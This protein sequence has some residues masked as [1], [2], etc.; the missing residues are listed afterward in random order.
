MIQKATAMGTWWQAA[1]SRQHVC[2]CIMS[3]ADFFGET[4]NH[5]GDSTPLQPRFGAL[6]LLAFPQIKIT[7]ERGEVSDPWWNSG[8]YDREADDD[9]ENCVR[10]QDAYFEGDWGVAVLCTM[11]LYLV[12]SSTNVSIF[13]MT[14]LDTS[15]TNLAAPLHIYS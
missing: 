1:S 7:S 5:P 4:S 2:S 15:W 13:S 8:K 10:S 11:L 9:W 12:S 14:W 6:W 3:R